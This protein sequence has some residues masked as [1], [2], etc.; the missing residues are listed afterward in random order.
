MSPTELEDPREAETRYRLLVE[1]IPAILY[2]DEVDESST[3]ISTSPQVVEILGIPHQEWVTTRDLWVRQM[4]PDDR[5]RVLAENEESNRTGN[6]FRTEYRMIHRD[7]R[8]VWFRDE[9]VIVRDE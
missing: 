7:G 6:P 4:H 8:E 2:M 1:Q 3:N 9:A 5:E